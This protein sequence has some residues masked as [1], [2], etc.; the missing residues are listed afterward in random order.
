[1]LSMILAA[2]ETIPKTATT[3]ISCT[4]FNKLSYYCPEPIEK[5]A[6]IISCGLNADT[7]ATVIEIRE[8]NAAY[9]SLN[10]PD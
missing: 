10:C 8:H 5:N 6:K 3:D 7:P 9:K 1:M 4:A 2:C